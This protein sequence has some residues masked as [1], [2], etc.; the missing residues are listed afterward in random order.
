MR[1]LV[2]KAL[3][4]LSQESRRRNKTSLGRTCQIK[5][6][7]GEHQKT[8]EPALDGQTGWFSG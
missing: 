8:A 6:L 1:S 5:D 4:S 2:Y 7:D 3:G